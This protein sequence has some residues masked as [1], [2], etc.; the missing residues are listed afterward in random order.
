MPAHLEAYGETWKKHHP[1][2]DFRLWDES[3]LPP[4]RNQRVYDQA[5]TIAPSSEGQLRADVARYELLLDAGGVWID[6][7]LECLRPIDSLLDGVECF[8]GWESEHR[9]VNNAIFGSVPGHPFLADLVRGLPANVRRKRGARPNVLTGPQY[10][11]P[12]YRRHAK[13]VTVFPKNYF[14][15][16][17]WNQLERRGEDFT[18]SYAVHH[19]NNARRRQHA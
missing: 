10:V 12:V 2:W 19:W 9:W 6:A 4:L 5:E 11:T 8:A 1:S 13:A 17:L 18:G 3:N 15:P 7:D 14:Y 16:Y